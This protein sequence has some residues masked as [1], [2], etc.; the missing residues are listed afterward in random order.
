M[1]RHTLDTF[2]PPGGR[3]E[4]NHSQRIPGGSVVQRTRVGGWGKKVQC[5][6]GHS[7]EVFYTLP[8]YGD[9]P[10]LYQCLVS[11]DLIAVSPDAEQYIGPPWDVKRKDESCP[12][13]AEPLA[14]APRYPET[15]RCPICGALN[16]L[17]LT[18]KKYPADEERTE[19][20][21][22]DPYR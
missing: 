5:Q 6:R 14:F 21:A 16:H 9:A 13:C 19:F 18:V 15:F 12:T 20:S 10:V 11:G 7:V 2:G 1:G 3:L 22:W 17:E 4:H 8:D